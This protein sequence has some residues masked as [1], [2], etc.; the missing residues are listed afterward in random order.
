MMK[1]GNKYKREKQFLNFPIWQIFWRKYYCSVDV[2]NMILRSMYYTVCVWLCPVTI[3]RKL[4]LNM[5]KYNRIIETLYFYCPW[6]KKNVWPKAMK[7]MKQLEW[8]K[9]LSRFGPLFLINHCFLPL[10][11]WAVYEECNEMVF[12]IIPYL[13]HE[14]IQITI[15]ISLYIAFVL[16]PINYNLRYNVFIVK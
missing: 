7:N 12:V 3:H 11:N 8:I 10:T 14:W 5:E 2:I 15:V 13:L 16:N 6:F 4:A 1:F 9:Y